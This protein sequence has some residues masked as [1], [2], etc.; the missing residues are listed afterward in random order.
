METGKVVRNAGWIII[1]RVAQAILQLVVSMLTARYLGPSNYGIINYAASL[2]AFV[3]PIMQLGLSSIL[4][5]EIINRE[6]SDGE[7]IGTALS[8]CLLSAIPCVLGV[9]CFACIANAGETITIVVCSLYSMLLFFQAFEVIQYWFQAKLLSKYTSILSLIAYFLVSAYKVFL[10]ITAK[11][12]YWF[13]VSNALDYLII[14]IGLL[15]LFKKFGNEPFKFSKVTAVRMFNKSKYYIVS[16]LMVTVFAQT[17]RIMIKLMMNDAATG[18][19]SAAV[20]C[21]GMTSF[22]FIAIIDSA[23]PSIFE[24]KKNENE[25]YEKNII[26]L[27][28]L[29]IYM[30]IVQSVVV[31]VFARIIIN[32]L[33]GNAYL[34]SI[35]PLRL[36][37]WY[38]TFSYM[39]S[40]R[41]IWIL[42]EGKQKYL[43][44]IN[45]S[46]AGMNIVLN[47]ILIPFMGIMGA[48][49]AS[50]FTQFFTNFLVSYIIQPI[51]YNNSLIIKSLNPKYCIQILEKILNSRKN[52]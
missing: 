25:S 9:G 45:L 12:I 5:Q 17:D 21:A 1:C 50:V 14:A 16:S 3:V 8:M 15:I 7:T 40:V 44:I 39:G 23:R 35:D 38:T 10:L 46:G 27:Y 49:L 43:W 19:Y 37:V 52:A 31:T 2:V 42:A 48:A 11:S 36:V 30:A 32:I 22:V 26:R 6:V 33:Y 28:S 41:N 51:A 29:I 4:V 34:E 20:A 18:F 24:S 47:S 13:A